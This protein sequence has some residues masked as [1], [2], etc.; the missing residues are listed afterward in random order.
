METTTATKSTI[1]LS[2]R[3]NP[4][5]Q[6]IV[7]TISYA[8]LPVMN[9]SLH[10]VLVK[11]N[12]IIQNAASFSCRHHCCWNAPPTSS[13]FGECEH[14]WSPSVFSMHQRISTGAPFYVWS[15]CFPHTSMSHAIL[16]N[17][18]SA[19]TCRTATNITHHGRE[20][21]TSTAAPPPSASDVMGQHN[22]M[23]G[24]T[25]GAALV[26]RCW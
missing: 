5:L 21:S 25:S 14:I 20:G 3:A 1:T 10:A 9:K 19:A 24:I 22:K 2:D 26:V 17:W 7:T 12:M 6:N 8:F 16:S 13:L 11:I 15:V 4:Q 23:G 18:P